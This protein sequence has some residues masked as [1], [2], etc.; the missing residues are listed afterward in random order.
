MI[1]VHF[2]EKQ[3]QLSG[4]S[5]SGHA[6]YAAY[7]QD[8]VCASVTSAVQLTANGI[9]EIVKANCEVNAQEN[10]VTLMLGE[11]GAKAEE[12]LHFLQ[13]LYLHLSIL[14]E[15]YPKSV[16]VIVSEV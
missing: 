9:T 12:A 3:G 10:C 4:V 11:T 7:G 16:K 13:A 6:G 2:F 15:D 1:S 8:I 14:A 5:V